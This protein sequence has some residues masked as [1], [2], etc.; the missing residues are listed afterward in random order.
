MADQFRISLGEVSGMIISP[1]FLCEHMQHQCFSVPYPFLSLASDTSLLFLI[2]SQSLR[3][4]IKAL[5]NLV[6]RQVII[7]R[8]VE[9][10]GQ[11]YLGIILLYNSRL[12]ELNRPQLK[13]IFVESI[14]SVFLLLKDF[15]NHLN[16]ALLDQLDLSCKL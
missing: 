14:N 5:R 16:V 2:I 3:L 15:A 7:P 1:L 11:S 10:F 8:L 12:P 13:W 4:H 6:F 9:T